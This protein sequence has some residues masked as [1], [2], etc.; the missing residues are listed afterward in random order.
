MSQKLLTLCQV[1]TRRLI[2]IIGLLFALILVFQYLELPYGS[3]LPSLIPAGKVPVLGE[4]SLQN[5]DV[6]PKSKIVGN[7]SPSSSSNYTGTNVSR[8]KLNNTRIFGPASEGTVGSEGSLGLDVDKPG[9]KEFSPGNLEK[10]NKTLQP[11]NV[12]SVDNGIP[13]EE[14]RQPKQ[15]F[16]GKINA[17]YNNS[18]TGRVSEETTVMTSNEVETLDAGLPSPSP[19]IPPANWSPNTTETVLD[20]NISTPAITG[21]FNTSVV[22]KNRTISS[23]KNENSET[24][25]VDLRQN[26]VI[27]GNS[28]TSLVEKNGT[29][30][31]EKN[32]NSEPV[33]ANLKAEDNNSSMTPVPKIINK[34]QMPVLDVYSLYDMD[35]LLL[36]S[37]A[38]YYSVV[39]NESSALCFKNMTC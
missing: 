33:H 27:S 34:P 36:Q 5:E 30:T 2:W 29:I 8:D 15:S 31:S 20:R 17:T 9:G 4:G 39:R 13:P 12:K 28:N 37:H 35:N 10:E 25:H 14:A 19:A 16:N 18:S 3:F 11:E 7:V 23:E 1:E 22:E 32:E 24:L 21:N 26:P 6:S 38:S